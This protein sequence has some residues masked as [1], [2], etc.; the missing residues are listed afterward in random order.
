MDE[1]VHSVFGSCKSY[2]LRVQAF[3]FV[4]VKQQLSLCMA[5]LWK[6]VL[7]PMLDSGDF[8]QLRLLRYF[9]KRLKARNDLA[10]LS[11]SSRIEAIFF[12]IWKLNIHPGLTHRDLKA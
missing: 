12:N 3:C 5:V 11:E 6:Y 9:S 4:K 2:L 7:P 1:K 10:F 8:D